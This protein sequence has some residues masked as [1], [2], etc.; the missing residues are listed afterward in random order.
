MI[1][2]LIM[3]IFI[4]LLFV[5]SLIYFKKDVL[6]PSIITTFVF[7]L[8]SLCVIINFKDWNVTYNVKTAFIVCCGLLVIVLVECFIKK[9]FYKVVSIDTKA[10]SVFKP[11]PWLIFLVVIL[12]FLFLAV[13]IKHIFSLG[14]SVGITGL[15]A[16]GQVKDS[17]EV[18]I[19]GIY[20]L[21]YDYCH[22]LGLLFIYLFC[23]NVFGAKDKFFRNIYLLLPVIIGIVAIIFRGARGPLLQYLAC[24]FFLI[25]LF[26]QT[27]I[28]KG[29][30][31][32]FKF[33][34][35]TFIFGLL[36]LIVFYSLKEIV[37][38]RE[39]NASFIDYITYYIGSPLYLFD[40]VVEN[41][42]SVYSGYNYFGVTTFTN[43][44]G[45]LYQLGLIKNPVSG[46]NFYKINLGTSSLSGNEYTFF[47]RPYYD[48]GFFG[49]LL[50]VGLFY[51]LFNLIYYCRIKT[52]Y[53]SEKNQKIIIIYS[54]FFYMIVMSFYYCFI[55]QD[56]R[57]QILIL[58]LFIMLI[59]DLFKL[60]TYRKGFFYETN[61]RNNFSRW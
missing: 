61:E 40:K 1:V 10:I 54:L 55:A 31:S 17:S 50:F 24:F 14:E 37:K 45:T 2:F 5:F 49:M 60:V 39:N 8:S 6:S 56:F 7:L 3:S 53:T 51:G 21:M 26:K 58:I 13:F 4:F 16:I 52:N 33:I 11:Q 20:L 42:S 59:Y 12:D 36:F 32:R 30:I 28:E 34:L 48:F 23:R 47:M 43:L 57:P 22:Y 38:G 41:P 46:L 25:A 27:N 29:F 35:K 19:S 9:L 18:S 15:F 44:Y